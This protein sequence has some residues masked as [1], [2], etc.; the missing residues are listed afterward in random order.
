MKTLLKRVSWLILTLSITSCTGKPDVGNEYCN[1][2]NTNQVVGRAGWSLTVDD[3]MNGTISYTF[4]HK[5][6]DLSQ[7]NSVAKYVASRNTVSIEKFNKE[8]NKNGLS[9]NKCKQLYDSIAQIQEV[10]ESQTKKNVERQ[11]KEEEQRKATFLQ[12]LNTY[13]PKTGDVVCYHTLRDPK[14]RNSSEKFNFLKV[15]TIYPQDKK[16]DTR[17]NLRKGIIND[18][19]TQLYPDLKNDELE[20]ENISSL[21]GRMKKGMEYFRGKEECITK[22]KEIFSARKNEIQEIR[23]KVDEFYCSFSG[24]YWNTFFKVKKIHSNF[25]PSRGLPSESYSYTKYEE[26]KGKLFEVP[27][28]RTIYFPMTA[29]LDGKD[30]DFISGYDNC[31]KKIQELSPEPDKS[32]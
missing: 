29:F 18:E 19:M 14:D 8:L 30:K 11:N 25:N 17:W 31:L 10:R 28:S 12:D 26:K 6:F 15:A 32:F 21:L 1:L 20:W 2:D 13:I 7:E 24:Y 9:E 22:F 16:E 27:E 3:V 4:K 23:L 5:Y